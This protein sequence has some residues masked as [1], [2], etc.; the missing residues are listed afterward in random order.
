VLR[1]QVK[2]LQMNRERVCR[3]AHS[4]AEAEF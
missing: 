4:R 3:D 2:R 1:R